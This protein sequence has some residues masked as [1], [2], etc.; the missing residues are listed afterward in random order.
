MTQIIVGDPASTAALL[1]TPPNAAN[2]RIWPAA[3]AANDDDPGSSAALARGLTAFEAE[4]TGREP[5]L[6]LL[7]DDSDAALAATLVATKLLIPVA[8]VAAASR[9]STANGRLIAQL[10]EAYTRPA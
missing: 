6:V 1:E 3:A 5:D 10:A 8:A 2:V 4:V 9:P 7:A